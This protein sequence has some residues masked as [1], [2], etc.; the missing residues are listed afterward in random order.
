MNPGSRNSSVTVAEREANFLWS[1]S[2]NNRGKFDKFGKMHPFEIFRSFFC[3]V[4]EIHVGNWKA[5]LSRCPAG[6]WLEKELFSLI[7]YW[8]T[9]VLN[10]VRW[11]LRSHNRVFQAEK[12]WARTSVRTHQEKQLDSCELL[13]PDVA[14]ICYPGDFIF[15]AFKF[16]SHP[17]TTASE[18]ETRTRGKTQKQHT[19]AAQGGIFNYLNVRGNLAVLFM[20][21]RLNWKRVLRV[22][23]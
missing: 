22:K 19:P 1:P 18:P 4:V 11:E 6:R 8:V 21:R 17:T 23:S 3:F 12:R 20:G 13:I 7:F 9:V 14:W 2:S 5:N 10:R 16:S 15:W